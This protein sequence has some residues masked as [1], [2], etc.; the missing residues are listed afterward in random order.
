MKYIRHS[1]DFVS[2]EFWRR[3]AFCDLVF[4]ENDVAVTRLMIYIYIY[5][6][7]ERETY[8]DIY[9]YVYVCMYV[10]IYIYTYVYIVHI[11]MF[12]NFYCQELLLLRTFAENFYCS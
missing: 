2:E 9:M 10:Y 8:I 12:K 1:C 6:E 3:R 4:A 5:R 7:R 11:H